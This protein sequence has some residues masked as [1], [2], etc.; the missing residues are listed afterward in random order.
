[1]SKFSANHAAA[2]AY[3]DQAAG[4]TQFTNERAADAA[5]QALRR[6]IR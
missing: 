4:V 6:L 5:V 1:M 3:I 2:V